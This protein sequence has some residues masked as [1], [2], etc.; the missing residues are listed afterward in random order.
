MSRK[1]TSAPCRSSGVEVELGRRREDSLL[2]KLPEVGIGSDETSLEDLA[3]DD[4][5]IR[6]RRL[7]ERADHLGRSRLEDNLFAVRAARLEVDDGA[8]RVAERMLRDKD[9]S[10]R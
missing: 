1:R 2:D 9:W 5:R 4:G 10:A 3:S 7:C 6:T 8:D